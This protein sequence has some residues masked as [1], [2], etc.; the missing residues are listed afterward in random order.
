MTTIALRHPTLTIA[1]MSTRRSQHAH[2]LLRHM[3]VCFSRRQFRRLAR[4]L[5]P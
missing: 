1:Y 2:Q 4:R 5:M 3:R